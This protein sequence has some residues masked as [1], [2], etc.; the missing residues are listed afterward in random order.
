MRYVNVTG[1]ARDDEKV[2]SALAWLKAK[3]FAAFACLTPGPLIRA[4]SG[5]TLTHMPSVTLTRP[6]PYRA[7][8][9]AQVKVDKECEFAEEADCD[10]KQDSVHKFCDR[11]AKATLKACFDG[12]K[13]AKAAQAE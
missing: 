2:R 11:T 13:A 8:K 9:E 10:E 1:G 7:C 12:W 3:G 6:S 4:T 5:Y